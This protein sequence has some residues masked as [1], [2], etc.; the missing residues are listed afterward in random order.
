[1]ESNLNDNDDAQFLRN[2]CLEF[3]N[4]SLTSVSKKEF[5]CFFKPFRFLLPNLKRISFRLTPLNEEIENGFTIEK[6][7]HVLF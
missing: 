5:S 7:W 4:F 1:M 6:D 3:V 2:N